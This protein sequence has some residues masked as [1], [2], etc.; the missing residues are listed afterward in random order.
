M[1]RALIFNTPTDRRVRQ[2]ISRSQVRKTRA[3]IAADAGVSPATFLKIRALDW[4]RGNIH[5][6]S[7][8]M[9]GVWLGVFEA[10]ESV[11]EDDPRLRKIAPRYM[12]T[13]RGRCAQQWPGL[14]RR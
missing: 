7:V 3:A 11:R 8:F 10:T 1:S 12:I 13:S 14:T 4:E 9:V 5:W 6:T 2:V